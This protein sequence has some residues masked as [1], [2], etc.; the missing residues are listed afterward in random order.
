MTG[1]DNGPIPIEIQDR[2]QWV[3]WKYDGDEKP[4]INAQDGG[5]AKSSESS[6]W[7]YFGEAY[8]FYRAHE[9][10]DGAGY[11][12][13]DQDPFLVID[14][15][16][17]R[18]PETE[19]IEDWAKEI[20]DT[21]ASYT[22]VSPSWTGL[23]IWVKG[24]KPGPKN[25]SDGV[26]MYE[27]GQYITVTGQ[28]LDDTPDTIKERQSA[29]ESVYDEHLA[30]TED[31]DSTQQ[32]AATGHVSKSKSDVDPNISGP[33]NSLG[34]GEVLRR[35]KEA[36]N[37]DYFTELW[38]G[39]WEENT[40]RR[41]DKSRSAADQALC[42]L[43]AFWTGGNR[44]QMDRLFRDSGLMRDQWDKKHYKEGY[45]YGC[46]SISNA[47]GHQQECGRFYEKS[48]DVEYI[49]ESEGVVADGGEKIVSAGIITSIM[50]VLTDHDR[51]RTTTIADKIN[52]HRDSERQIRRALD[53]LERW[54]HI[55]YKKDGRKGY[56]VPAE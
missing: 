52:Y 26:E 29:I 17:C 20:V 12:P 24:S 8:D 34:D 6:T 7:T 54:E 41:A 40:D 35:A 37:G 47:I 45:T 56:W 46:G 22:E 1:V 33:G 15:D 4:P 10:I 9:D 55:E 51:L 18:D 44:A 31:S 21:F 13:T 14:L 36:Q 42:A 50:D 16:G 19:Q 23:H 25:R 2:R 30:D 38:E 3:C 48:V 28:P 11:V 5:R 43:L 53:F 32:S 49:P 39:N 27:S